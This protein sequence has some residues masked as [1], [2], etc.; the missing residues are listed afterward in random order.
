MLMDGVKRSTMKRGLKEDG[1][2]TMEAGDRCG[3]KETTLQWKIPS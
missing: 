1:Q 2:G 3:A